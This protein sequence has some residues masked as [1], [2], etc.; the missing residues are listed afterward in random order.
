M[1]AAR[2]AA[3]GDGRQPVN[4][5]LGRNGPSPSVLLRFVVFALVAGTLTWFVGARIHGPR[6]PDALVL[7][8]VFDDVGGLRSGD[9]VKIAGTPVGR[10]TD[11]RVADGRALVTLRIDRTLKLPPDSTAEVRWRDLIGQRLLYLVPGTGTGAPLR[12][13]ATLTATKAVV[14]LGEIVNQLG[15]LTRGLDPAQLNQILQAVA[16]MM[17]GNGQNLGLLMVDLQTLIA[18]FADRREQIASLTDD[19]AKLSDVAAERDDQIATLIGDLAAISKSFAGNTD[20]L[21]DAADE[22]GQ[23]AA[24]LD[25]VLSGNQKQLGQA[26]ANLSAITDTAVANTAK[27]EKA[28][29]QLPPT[30]RALFTLTNGGHFARINVMCFNVVRAPCPWPLRLPGQGAAQPPA[31]AAVNL[32]KLAD[33]M[34]TLTE[35]AD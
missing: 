22:L 2:P 31:D 21:G 14:D 1:P 23:V 25:T 27:I 12:D 24:S 17:E 13:G 16:R 4:G 33:L 9:P 6:Y 20:L 3:D 35:E 7:K 32:K 19:F 15:P 34:S 11:V 5:V 29:T 8:A 30:L 10:V 28:I 18:T 26:I